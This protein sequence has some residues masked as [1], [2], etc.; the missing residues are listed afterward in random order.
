MRASYFAP[1]LLFNK[2]V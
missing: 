2:Q 1:E